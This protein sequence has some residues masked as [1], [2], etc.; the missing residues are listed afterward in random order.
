[1]IELNPTKGNVELKNPVTVVRGIDGATFYPEVDENS[2]LSWTND[3]DLENPAPISIKGEKGDRGEKG[4]KGND[5]Y[6]PIKG[7]DYFDGEKGDKG[8]KGEPGYTPRKGVDY[9]D[10]AKGDK[11]E[12]G[13]TPV[14]G[15]D[16]FDGEKG[17][18][19]EPGYTPRKGVDYFDGEK[20]EKG[21]KGEPGAKG[22]KGDKGNDGYTPV[23]GVDYFDGDKGDKGEKGDKGD[24]G[25]PGADGYTP[26]KGIDYFD[27]AKGEKGDK[28]D[29]YT[30]TDTDKADIAAQVEVR[31]ESFTP[32]EILA[33][34][35]P[36][37]KDFATAFPD[38][39][40]DIDAGYE[41]SNMWNRIKLTLNKEITEYTAT[42]TGYVKSNGTI[43]DNTNGKRT[44]YI[45]IADAA[46]IEYK[47][48]VVE[49]YDL[50]SLAL[51]DADKNLIYASGEYGNGGNY[52]FVDE[53]GKTIVC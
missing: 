48:F 53:K 7:V 24:K 17:D 41:L 11:G 9:F 40:A 18:K 8:D 45:D 22:E 2:I 3:K 44:D 29:T 14:K 13:Y 1:M 5:G 49:A 15:I 32:D 10:G 46:K 20:G 30:L 47:A 50:V 23:K 19:G 27:G 16:Y 42:I 36:T 33:I 26:V 51:F 37:D 31:V 38:M 52:A 12:D 6:T 35:V 43:S 21:D 25:E 4:E 28:G 39:Q 34:C